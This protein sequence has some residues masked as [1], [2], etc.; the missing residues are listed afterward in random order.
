M[1]RNDIPHTCFASKEWT[2][3]CKMEPD[4]CST[5]C[6]LYRNIEDHLDRVGVPKINRRDRIEPR[7]D[8]EALVESGVTLAI[9]PPS[10]DDY[11]WAQ[12]YL[13]A[14][15]L[16]RVR[17]GLA[18]RDESVLWANWGNVTRLQMPMTDTGYNFD[19]DA[20]MVFVGVSISYANAH[21]ADATFLSRAYKSLPTIVLFSQTQEEL[22]RF[23]SIKSSFQSPYVHVMSKGGITW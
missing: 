10:K 23:T 22:G 12:S 14:E 9:T 6:F 2:G 16:K 7:K 21:L 11:R 3:S 8:I 18:A 13:Q 17:S 5:S 15:L 20:L 19:T 1:W 4:G